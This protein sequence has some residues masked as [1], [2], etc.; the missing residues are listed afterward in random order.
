M[1]SLL[2]LILN[3]GLLF[4][5]VGAIGLGLI[6][7]A[8]AKLVRDHVSWGGSMMVVGVIAVLLARFYLTIS[9][10]ILDDGVL[11]MIGPVGISLNL[12]I[13]PLF[14]SLGLA[15]IVWGLWVHERGLSHK[16]R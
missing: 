2:E 10:H 11:N 3:H 4:D 14:L 12:G 16:G 15:S 5:S 6:G 8:A 9:P 13:P 1:N 7:L